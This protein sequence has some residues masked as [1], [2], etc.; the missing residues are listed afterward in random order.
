VDKQLT[1]NFLPLGNTVLEQ[2][3]HHPIL[4]LEKPLTE[5][6]YDTDPKQSAQSRV[7]MLTMPGTEQ[8]PPARLSLRVSRHRTR[9][10]GRRRLPRLS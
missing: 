6:A 10:Q 2:N 4:L 3:A 8:D 9:R 7:K 5:F 1:D